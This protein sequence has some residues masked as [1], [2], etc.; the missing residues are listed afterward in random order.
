M[1]NEARPAEIVRA[2]N[3]P[4]PRARGRG[5]RNNAGDRGRSEVIYGFRM[6]M[7]DATQSA[8]LTSNG[9]AS[10]RRR[11]RARPPATYRRLR[12]APALRRL[13]PVPKVL[14]L[15][16]FA[17]ASQPGAPGCSA[18]AVLDVEPWPL[19]PRACSG[20]SQRLIWRASGACDA[21]SAGNPSVPSISIRV[22][23]KTGRRRHPA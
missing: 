22:C 19:R 18:P 1:V 15:A 14:R 7:A 8:S 5:R 12:P 3:R 16:P 11:P 23:G 20:G 2:R 17:Q 10:E 21:R 13:F 9:A 4:R 6:A